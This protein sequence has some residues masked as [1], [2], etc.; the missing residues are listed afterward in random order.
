MVYTLQIFPKNS[1]YVTHEKLHEN[2]AYASSILMQLI[3]IQHKISN[4]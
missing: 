1:Q 2:Y 4:I 3:V